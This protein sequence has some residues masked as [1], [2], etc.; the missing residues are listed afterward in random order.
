MRLRQFNWEKKMKRFQYVLAWMLVSGFSAVVGRDICGQQ[1]QTFEVVMDANLSV[2]ADAG[3]VYVFLSKRNPQPMYGP[4][5]FGTEPFFAVEVDDFG[6]GDS[7]IVDDKA[8]SFPSPP[9]KLKGDYVVQAIFDHDFYCASHVDGA[10]NVFSKPQSLR[11][12]SGLTR[13]VLDRIVPPTQ[14]KDTSRGKFVEIRSARLSEFHGREVIE[15]ALV[16]LPPSYEKDQNRRY[17]VYYEVSGFGGTL[18]SMTRG[19]QARAAPLADD[20]TEFIKVHLT[21]QCK[22]GHHVYANSQ[23]NGP[24]G[25]ALVHE[26]IPEIDRRF[27]TIA[28][29]SARF[30]GGHS[31]G[32]WSSLWLQVNYPET[33]DGCWSTSPDPVDFRDWQGTDLYAENANVY[34]DQAGNNRPVARAGDRVLAYYVDFA[35]MDDVLGRGGQLRSFEAVFSPIGSDGLPAH[36]WNRTSGIVDPAVLEHWK[37][38]DISLLL[39][40][41]WETLG[42]KLAGK[43]HVYMGDA[44]TFLLEGATKRLA[45]RLRELGSDAVV[46]VFPGRDHGNL[47]DGPMLKRIRREMS[48]AFWKNHP[49]TPSPTN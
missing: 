39:K 19:L 26:M 34:V 48:S 47:R 17:P 18:S 42:P 5:W 28:H 35:K 32:G 38:Y 14:Y 37:K 31:S 10:G 30:V 43:L 1:S 6:P 8:S 41:N 46:E 49:P 3:R 21:G 25:D 9:S 36:C 7:V 20:E 27:R 12:G 33:F 16:E 29:S 23:T 24:R 40:N 2:A 22:W 11:L 15:R 13:I 44:D 4:A 45:E